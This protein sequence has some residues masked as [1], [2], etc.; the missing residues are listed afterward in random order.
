MVALLVVFLSKLHIV[1]HSDQGLSWRELWLSIVS[2]HSEWIREIWSV[3]QEWNQRTGDC[4]WGE[5]DTY[6][7]SLSDCRYKYMS[8]ECSW[9]RVAWFF[10]YMCVGGRGKSGV[11]H[12]LIYTFCLYISVENKKAD[13]KGII[14]YMKEEFRRAGRI[15]VL[16][17]S[18][19]WKK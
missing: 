10:M 5:I 18:I 16:N 7:K 1:F 17:L 11:A 14:S 9:L 19:S 2:W 13:S 4:F 15:G 12:E 6:R 8:G 3:F